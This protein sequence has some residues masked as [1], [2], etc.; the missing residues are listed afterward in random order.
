MYIEPV[1]S[2]W[3][4]AYHCDNTSWLC[5]TCEVSLRCQDHTCILNLLQ[6]HSPLPIIA[7]ILAGC[8]SKTNP[9]RVQLLVCAWLRHIH[10]S[11]GV[12]ALSASHLASTQVSALGLFSFFCAPPSMANAFI[13]EA[14]RSYGGKGWRFETH[15]L[16]HCEVKALSDIEAP[17]TVEDFLSCCRQPAG[18]K[19]TVMILDVQLV[20]SDCG[21]SRDVALALK[22]QRVASLPEPLHFAETPPA[23]SK[24]G[25]VV[26]DKGNGQLDVIKYVTFKDKGATQEAT[27]FI[28][29]SAYVPFS[30][31]GLW[32]VKKAFQSLLDRLP[33][34]HVHW[35]TVTKWQ[36][37][38]KSGSSSA[39]TCAPDTESLL[40]GVSFVND[41]APE[42]DANNEQY[43]WVLMNI[44]ED[45]DSPI[46]GW[47]ETKVRIMAQNKSRASNG[48]T[49]QRGFPLT[50]CSLRPFLADK[51][52][53]LLYPLFVCY[54]VIALGWPGVGKTPALI[55]VILAMGRFHIHRLQEDAMPGWRRAKSL[56]NFRHQVANVY[57]GIFLDDPNREN[58]SGWPE[59]FLDS[60]RRTNHIWSLQ[61]R[62]AH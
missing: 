17:L 37:Q 52:L 24:V 43:T 30:R 35:S 14:M 45:S 4:F 29:G 25:G 2:A 41:N 8:V 15:A 36:A 62:K 53:P 1:A 56:D 16:P 48:A 49:L 57:E 58:I 40:Q 38:S 42:T 32:A 6:V 19:T 7:T 28:A 46:A 34:H 20:M 61:R 33:G 26:M 51:L 13:D 47:P 12:L 5:V 44:K 60:G 27:K 54:G 59:V 31:P 39:S 3:P 18:A 9:T 10:S 50:T 21:S 55:T 23:D 22:E 11:S